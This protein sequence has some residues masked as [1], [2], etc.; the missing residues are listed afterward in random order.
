LPPIYHSLSVACLVDAELELLS[1]GGAQCQCVKMPFFG[2][3]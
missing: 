2:V 1:V 3:I